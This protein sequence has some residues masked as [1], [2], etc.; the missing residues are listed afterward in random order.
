VRTLFVIM[1]LGLAANT[2]AAKLEREIVN[3]DY[4]FMSPDTRGFGEKIRLGKEHILLTR[5]RRDFTSALCY[6]LSDGALLFQEDEIDNGGIALS[7]TEAFVGRAL[8]SVVARFSLSDGSRLTTITLPADPPE[9]TGSSFGYTIE[10]FGNNVAISDISADMSD[11]GTSRTGCVYV[12]DVATSTLVRTLKSPQGMSNWFGET[13]LDSGSQLYIR[14]RT[15]SEPSVSRLVAFD[16]EGNVL[17]TMVEPGLGPFHVNATLA[18]ADNLLV[19]GTGAA[20]EYGPFPNSKSPGGFIVYNSSGTLVSSRT[21][22][23]SQPEFNLGGSVATDGK[24]IFV[25]VGGRP[26]LGSVRI[27]NSKGKKLGT[28]KNPDPKNVRWF[29]S[30]VRYCNGRLAIRGWRSTNRVY[31]GSIFIYKL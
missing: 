22:K 4:P 26:R 10:A 27:Y 24:R 16:L 11:N 17:Y 25:G 18:A 23:T 30:T 15:I 12:Y 3:P 5:T 28:I 7:D 20:G 9:D 29:G 21:G 2:Y 19:L 14:E 6:R 13:M 1:C 31:V 8:S